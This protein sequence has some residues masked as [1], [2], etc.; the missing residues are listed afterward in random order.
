MKI[1]DRGLVFDATTQPAP[2]R[3]NCFTSALVRQD[4]R[5]LVAFRAGSSKDSPDENIII[6]QSADQGK[7]WETL[8]EGLALVVDGVPGAWRH[9][10]LSELPDGRLIANFCWFDRSVPGRPLSNPVTQGTLPSRVFVLESADDGRTWTDR[11][12]VDTRPYAGIATTGEIMRMRDGGLA[13]PYETWKGYDDPRPGEHHAIL[14]VSHDGAHTF[15]PAIIVAHDAAANL[16]YWDQRV[17]IDPHTGRMVGLFWTHDR[18]AGQDRNIHIAWG[19]PDGKV[20]TTPTD[21]GVAGQIAYPLCLPGDRLLMVYVHR[22]EPPTL[23]ALLSAD[24][25]KTWDAAGELVFYDSRSG[26][27]SGMRGKR[28]FGDYWADMSVWS[29]GHP[30]AGR[31]PNGDVLVAF[32]GGNAQAMSMHWARIAL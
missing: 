8:F 16:F 4:G 11:R 7:T 30:T 25:G 6:R 32:Y 9:A 18:A 20:W 31:L 15:E 1:M 22:H 28:D 27:E 26:Q 13:L 23:R 29:F 12:E 10:G 19:S 21:T 24:F 2:R 3:F 5:W 14:R 17:G